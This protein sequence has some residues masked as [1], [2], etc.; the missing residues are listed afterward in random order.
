MLPRQ[1]ESFLWFFDLFFYSESS[2]WFH[3]RRTIQIIRAVHF[4]LAASYTLFQFVFFN[5]LYSLYNS[6]WIESIN[7]MVESLA[8]ILTYYLIILDDN[9]HH[10]VHKHFWTRVHQ[11]DE[12]F[13][14]QSNFTLRS[15]YVKFFRFILA[16]TIELMTFI[17]DQ[18]ASELYVYYICASLIKICQIRVLYYIFCLEVVRYQMAN[19][20]REF[21]TMKTITV[22]ERSKVRTLSLLEH[23]RL[24][25]V[26]SYF[27]SIHTMVNETFGWSQALGIPY[28]CLCL[29]AELNIFYMSVKMNGV[30]NSSISSKYLF[31]N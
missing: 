14:C 16:T 25:W 12:S 11:I 29:F 5:F 8:S 7:E 2:K 20:Q 9:V 15:F 26:R 4:L 23:Q 10:C 21:E 18:N 31:G 24:K 3:R 22:I 13:C 27:H 19:I 28:C 17:Y 30:P 1:L 6:G